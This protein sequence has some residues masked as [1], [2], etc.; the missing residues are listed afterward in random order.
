MG[1]WWGRRA[2]GQEAH[3]HVVVLGHL[4]SQQLPDLNERTDVVTHAT[5]HTT[6]N[7]HGTHDTGNVSGEVVREELRVLRWRAC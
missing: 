3:D 7:T 4:L 2:V 6:H 5:T 1:R